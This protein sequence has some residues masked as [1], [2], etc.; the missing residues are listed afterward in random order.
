MINSVQGWPLLDEIIDAIGR[1][2][3]FPTWQRAPLAKAM[4]PGADYSGLYENQDGVAFEVTQSP[5]GLALKFEQQAPILLVPA[6]DDEF[7]ATVL[8]L[9]V[10]FAKSDAGPPASMTV[11]S[12]GRRSIS[13]GKMSR[14]PKQ[15][16]HRSGSVTRFRPITELEECL[17]VA[18]NLCREQDTC[19]MATTSN[20]LTSKSKTRIPRHRY[21]VDE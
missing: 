5:E 20:L 18:F 10:N 7:F 15:L 16:A 14:S 13:P 6:S 19:T 1:E 9:W 12:G 17:E 8:N 21:P 2:F 11:Q 3:G 4:P